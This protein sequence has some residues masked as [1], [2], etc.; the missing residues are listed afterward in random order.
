MY[1]TSLKLRYI[2]VKITN[3]KAFTM[4]ENANVNKSMKNKVFEMNF[5]CC[6]NVLS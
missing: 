6:T 4:I 3:I 5:K 1:L 2:R